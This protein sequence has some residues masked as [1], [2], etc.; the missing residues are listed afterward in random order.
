MFFLLTTKQT[1]YIN[2]H[3]P[4]KKEVRKKEKSGKKLQKSKK[5]SPFY[6]KSGIFNQ[7]N[8]EKSRKK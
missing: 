7:K 8:K 3:P 2:T 1:P 4:Q 6:Q 5:K